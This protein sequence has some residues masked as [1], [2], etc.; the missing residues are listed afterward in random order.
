MEP[1]DRLKSLVPSPLGGE[2]RRQRKG[3]LEF[4]KENDL[5]LGDC[6]SSAEMGKIYK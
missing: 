3:L 6:L 4:F 5:S 2:A 1:G